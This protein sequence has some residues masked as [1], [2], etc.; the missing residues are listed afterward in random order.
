MKRPLSILALLSL[1]AS[2][3]PGTFDCLDPL[4]CVEVPAGAPLVIGVLAAA[5]GPEALAGQR[6]VQGV[7]SAAAR[8]E[9]LLGHPIEVVFQASDCSGTEAA[10]A[11]SQLA[12]DPDLLLVIGPACPVDLEIA[13]PYL[14][15]AGIAVIS[16]VF[17]AL[18]GAALAEQ[19]FRAIL[20]VAVQD[21]SGTHWIP[22]Q[23]LIDQPA[24]SP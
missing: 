9:D 13:A 10:R 11:A 1:L 18:P 21:G 16:P 5:S 17:S 23:A 3:R 19:A 15:S 14:A 12:A 22:R 7:E 4:G 24:L 8:Q 6:L 20:A 2:C